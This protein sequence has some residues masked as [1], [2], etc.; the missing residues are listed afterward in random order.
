MI[1]A[2]RVFNA[3]RSDENN[4]SL[5]ATLQNNM[6]RQASEDQRFKK[7]YGVHFRRHDNYDLIVDTSYTAP[8]TIARKIRDCFEQRKQGL[9]L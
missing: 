9:S 4:P 5:E 7:L 3:G 1:G 2:E 8:E 6:N